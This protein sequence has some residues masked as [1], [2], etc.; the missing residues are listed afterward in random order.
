MDENFFIE[1]PEKLE[2]NFFNK[3]LQGEFKKQFAEKSKEMVKI[4]S[5]KHRHAKKINKNRE[6]NQSNR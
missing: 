2:N 6:K 4:L 3:E 1:N 5:M